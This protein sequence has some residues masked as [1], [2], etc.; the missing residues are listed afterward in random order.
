[1]NAVDEKTPSSNRRHSG[2]LSVDDRLEAIEAKLDKLLDN[3]G[4][5]P[6]RVQKLEYVVYG[7]CGVILLAVLGAL[8]AL[9]VVQRH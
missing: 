9:V 1:V 5:L 6:D 7:G 8:V 4:S 2:D 3:T